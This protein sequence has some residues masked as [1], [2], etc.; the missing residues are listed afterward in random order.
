[1]LPT[2]LS[3]SGSVFA[4]IESTSTVVYLGLVTVTLAHSLWGA[5]LKRLSLSVAVVVGLLEPAVAAT[6]GIVVLSEPV[7][8]ALVVGICLVM[9]GVAVTS[10][11]TTAERR[12]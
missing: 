3:S 12:R 8:V 7:T 1:M 5:G 10:L 9:V 4:S 2:A 6:L 11:S